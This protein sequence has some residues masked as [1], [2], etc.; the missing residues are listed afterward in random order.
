VTLSEKP[1]RLEVIP[2]LRVSAAAPDRGAIKN[3]GRAVRK[4]KNNSATATTGSRA[5]SVVRHER[6]PVFLKTRE[7][8]GTRRR[9]SVKASERRA[10]WISKA[11]TADKPQSR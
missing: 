2:P 8:G 9:V 1:V 3:S 10:F 11:V 7:S 5:A 4:I 6:R